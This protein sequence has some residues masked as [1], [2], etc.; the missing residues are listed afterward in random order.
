MT[1]LNDIENRLLQRQEHT[2]KKYGLIRN[3]YYSFK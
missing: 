1:V 2:E 3:R